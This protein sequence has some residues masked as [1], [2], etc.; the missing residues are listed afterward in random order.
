M[1][2]NSMAADRVHPPVAGP[3]PYWEFIG[4]VGRRASLD[5]DEARLMIVGT[6]TALARITDRAERNRLLE[7]MPAALHDEL[8]AGFDEDHPVDLP[9]HRGTGIN[10]VVAVG[11]ATHRSLQHLRHGAQAVTAG[12]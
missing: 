7:I 12:S 2:G 5:L 1:S 4:R 10:M 8:R 9:Y 11:G 6:V 3:L